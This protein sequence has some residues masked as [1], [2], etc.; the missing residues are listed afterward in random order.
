MAKRKTNAGIEQVDDHPAG[1][2]EEGAQEG[3]VEAGFEEESSETED[4]DS[5][6]GT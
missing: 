3:P 4:L 6:P 1:V 2:E 5:D